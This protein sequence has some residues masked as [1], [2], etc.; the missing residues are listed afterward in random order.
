MIDNLTLNGNNFISDTLVEESIFTNNLSTVEIS[1]GTD[2]K[3]YT[4]MFLVQV[5]I[6]QGKWWFVLAEKS[7]EQ[8][9]KELLLNKIAELENTIDALFGGATV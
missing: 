8:V 2:T 4:D 5:T 9:E 3:V 1:D 7:A 6:F